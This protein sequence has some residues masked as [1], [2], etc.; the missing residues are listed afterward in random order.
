MG[1]AVAL[2]QQHRAAVPAML[3][4]PVAGGAALAAALIAEGA[5]AGAAPASVGRQAARLLLPL[6][7]HLARAAAEARSLELAQ[8]QALAAWACRECFLMLLAP[9]EEPGQ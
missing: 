5:A 7:V 9:A 2:G 4:L 6:M 3:A 8:Q 1:A